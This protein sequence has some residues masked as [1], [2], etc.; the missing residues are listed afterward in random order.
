[1][2]EQTPK[3]RFRNNGFV[4]AFEPEQHVRLDYF[5]RTRSEKFAVCYCDEEWEVMRSQGGFNSLDEALTV[6]EKA[7]DVPIE[8]WLIMPDEIKAW[9]NPSGKIFEDKRLA[10]LSELRRRQRAAAE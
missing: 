8:A 7:F 4:V 9:V 3:A 6:A 2:G 10:L 5:P 1:M